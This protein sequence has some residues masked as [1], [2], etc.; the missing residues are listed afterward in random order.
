M[1]R[2][3]LF[4]VLAAVSLLITL[5][6]V[7]LASTSYFSE[8]AGGEGYNM[9]RSQAVWLALS[10]VLCVV[11]ACLDFNL[12]YR[13]RW[14]VFGVAVVGLL[15]CYVPFLS[16][17][18][19]GARRWVTLK[20]LGLGFVHLQPS[21]F[22][23][24]ACAI[25]MAGWYVRNEP[26]TREFKYGFLLPGGVALTLIAVVAGEVDLGSATLLAA[27]SIGIMFVAGARMVFLLPLLV[28]AGGALWWVVK[29]MPN[30]VARVMA[31]MDLEK[32][33]DGLGL[34]QWR[35]LLCFGSGG[36]LG[37]GLGNG[38]Q[39][40]GF[41]PEPNT[42]FIFPNIGE[43]LGLAG[44]GFVVLMF[45]VL[46]AAGMWIAAHAPNR[47]GRLLGFGIVLTLAMEALLNM[48]VTTALLPNKGLP[49]PFVSYGGSSLLSAMLG[50]GILISIHR[51][52]SY[53]SKKDLLQLRRRRMTAAV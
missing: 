42:D 14:W 11:V 27:L 15:L 5:G 35:A 28:S 29:H 38:R 51:Q 8:E 23:K 44:A 2:F 39:K 17:V 41:L 24:I 46:A 49:L 32:Y 9:L 52:S 22:A 26:N 50:V 53:E 1:G 13:F 10:L 43:E 36:P 7:T 30:R 25:V 18:V 4:S 12:W 48:G 37:L 33:K 20:S 47:F 40:N 3:S 16:E 34:Q 6:L 19:N 45:V 31:F 21:E